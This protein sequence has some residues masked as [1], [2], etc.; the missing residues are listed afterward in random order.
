MDHPVHR[1]EYD[2]PK[3]ALDE[4]TLLRGKIDRIS[5]TG[6]DHEFL[7]VAD[8]KTG[9]R[10]FDPK[11]LPYGIGMQLPTYALALKEDKEYQDKKIIGLFISPIGL[12]SLTYD[13]S[14]RKKGAKDWA[15]YS[16]CAFQWK[17][18]CTSEQSELETL[19]GQ[20]DVQTL[21]GGGQI[22]Y[23]EED[24]NNWVETVKGK[25]LEA[26]QKIR[27]GRFPIHPIK[28]GMG[29]DGCSY[30]RF[31]DVCYLRE[32]MCNYVSFDDEEEE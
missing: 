2:F 10:S 14:A 26:S 17:G 11:K 4:H 20:S 3:I 28:A 22:R 32:S 29:D 31:R 30:C 6:Q 24:L 18:A 27:E 13:T 21:L 15:E 1:S 23:S 19:I 7:S 8:Y 16:S 12:G 25:Y 5:E 9:A